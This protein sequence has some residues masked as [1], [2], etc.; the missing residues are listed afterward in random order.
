MHWTNLVNLEYKFSSCHLLSVKYYN[1]FKL[2]IPSPLLGL[3]GYKHGGVS[4]VQNAFYALV[5][6]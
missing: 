1:L 4:P 2:Q 6:P 5:K 3:D